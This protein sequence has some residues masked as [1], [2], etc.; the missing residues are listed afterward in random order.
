MTAYQDLEARARGVLPPDV[1]GY[2]SGGSGEGRTLAEQ[3]SAWSDVRLRPRVLRDVSIVD[4]A[5]SVLGHRIGF[6]RSRVVRPGR[7]GRDRAGRA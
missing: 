4:T 7:R 3:E 5:V 6:C 2:L 1:F